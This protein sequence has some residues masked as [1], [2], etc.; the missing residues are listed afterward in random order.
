MN[1]AEVLLLQ[2][3]IAKYSYLYSVFKTWKEKGY[4]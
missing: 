3:L 2:E 1:R 4:I